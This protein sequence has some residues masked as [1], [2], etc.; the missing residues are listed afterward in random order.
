V[1]SLVWQCGQYGCCATICSMAGPASVGDV[2]SDVAVLEVVVELPPTDSRHG[3][4]A[5]VAVQ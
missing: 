4:M 5:S 1:R 2:Q 3:H